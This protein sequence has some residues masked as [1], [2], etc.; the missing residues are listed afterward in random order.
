MTHPA[1]PKRIEQII[2]RQHKLWDL[3]RA[4]ADEGGAAAAREY[5]NL[6]EGPW[7]TFSVQAGTAGLEIAGAVAA[8]LGW[9]VFDREI[10]STIAEHGD[11][12]ERVVARHDDQ[13]VSRLADYVAHL[14]VPGH[15]PH[16]G[17][18]VELIRTIA[19]IGRQGRAVL[20]GRGANWVLDPHFGLRVRVVAPRDARV[21]AI[22]AAAGLDD[23]SAGRRTDEYD[24]VKA[25]F[26]RQV[27]RREID[28][29]L[30]Y[31]LVLNLAT[32]GTAGGIEVVL[33]ALRGKLAAQTAPPAL[34]R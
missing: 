2:E 24:A 31:D 22:A 19:A 30:G 8:N 12:R 20:V 11:L 17:Y 9:Q 32:I 13:P 25:G 15:L 21:R 34:V 14:I 29:P 18:E 33:A 7:V 6:R 16:I 5:A 1:R 3:R 28:D 27:Y 23:T 26:I 4:L 10:L